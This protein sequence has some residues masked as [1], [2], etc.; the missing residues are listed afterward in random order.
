MSGVM[1]AQHVAN[2]G[3]VERVADVAYMSGC[4]GNASH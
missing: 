2:M 1:M 4:V 3:N